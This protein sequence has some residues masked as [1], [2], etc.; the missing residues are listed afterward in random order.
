MYAIEPNR[1][2]EAWGNVGKKLP[3]PKAI[4]VISAHWL[5]RGVSVTAMSKPAT[6]HDFGGFPPALF[7]EQYPA[8][9]SP[10][11]AQRVQSLLGNITPV[12]LDEDEWGLDHGAWSLLKYLYPKADIPV[13]QMSLDASLS[14]SAHYELAKNLAPLREEGVLILTS[15][16]VVHNLRTIDWRENAPALPWATEFNHFFLTQLKARNDQA[17]INWQ[18]AGHGALK[19]IPSP[20]HYWP[21]LYTLGVCDHNEALEVLTDGVELGSISMLGFSIGAH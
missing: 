17:L 21:V 9:G 10:E 16:N 15:G 5:T 18:N 3:K 7:E 14:D 2:T 19:S 12:K 11:L 4:L 6:I 13:V 20:D 1:Y 8:P